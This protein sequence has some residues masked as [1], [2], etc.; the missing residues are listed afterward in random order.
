MSRRGYPDSSKNSPGIEQL[1]ALRARLDAVDGHLLD[2]LAERI[3]CC[4][5][6]AEVKRQNGVSM[7]QPN[8]IGLVQ[9]NAAKYGRD[10]GISQDFLRCLYDVIIAETC[11]IEDLVIRDGPIT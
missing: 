5:K 1:D 8:R 10:N 3:E 7:M 4:K 6:I 2:T 9:R 11:R